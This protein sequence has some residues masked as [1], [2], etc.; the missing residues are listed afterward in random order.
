M[1]QGAT[2]T[3]QEMDNS[4]L[5]Q[6]HSVGG[7]EKCVNCGVFEGMADGIC[8]LMRH[9]ALEKRGVKGDPEGVGLD[10]GKEAVATFCTRSDDRS[11]FGRRRHSETLTNLSRSIEVTIGCT[12]LELGEEF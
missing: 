8:C 11:W 2:T 6:G 9:G 7:R 10:H 3:T 12:S 5:D 4:S 1:K